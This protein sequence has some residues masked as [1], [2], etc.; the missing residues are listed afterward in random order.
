MKEE[1]TKADLKDGMVVEYKDGKRRLVVADMLIGKDGFLTLNSY[2]EE[3]K[4]NSF[5]EHT[6]VKTYKIREAA[7]FNCVLDDVNLELIWKRTE[8]KRMTTE[9]MRKKLEELTGEKIE[10]EPSKEE[11]I[12]TRYEFCRRQDCSISCVLY[13]SGNCCFKNYSDEIIKQCY[14]KVMEDGRKES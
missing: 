1:F 13:K 12:G 6:I 14:E 5:D 4:N 10:V 9:E 7:T 2:S 8:T 11:M 3:L